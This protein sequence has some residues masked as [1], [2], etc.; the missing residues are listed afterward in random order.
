[1][2]G[3]YRHQSLLLTSK[4]GDRAAYVHI[5]T[6]FIAT[7]GLLYTLS[8]LRSRSVNRRIYP[9]APYAPTDGLLITAAF[10]LL[11]AFSQIYSLA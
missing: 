11:L 6:T 5:T 8:W 1:M 3:I 10:G 4:I 7:V 9:M 2:A